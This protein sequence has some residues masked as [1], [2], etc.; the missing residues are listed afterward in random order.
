M[1]MRVE[2]LKQIWEVA[3]ETALERVLVQRDSRGGA[4]FWLSAAG[5][6]FPCLAIQVSG[7]VGHVTFFPADGHP[8]FRCVGTKASLPDSITKL[9]FEG[10]D[11]GDGEQIPNRFIVPFSKALAIAKVFFRAGVIPDA[12]EWLEL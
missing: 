7:A 9:V 3:S 6:N 11:P 10:C 5:Q 2:G 8:G 1:N 12:E 4:E